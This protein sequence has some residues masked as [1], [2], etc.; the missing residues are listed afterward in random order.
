MMV[1][2]SQ[3][4]G[5]EF[6]SSHMMGF[7]FPHD[8]YVMVLNSQM[9]VLSSQKMNGEAEEKAAPYT[10][11]PKFFNEARNCG[12]SAAPGSVSPLRG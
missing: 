12:K 2:S 1:L 6:P 3:M 11:A 9:M 10:G 7:K 4:M 8:G 5:F